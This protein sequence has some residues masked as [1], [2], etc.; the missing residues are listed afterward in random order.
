VDILLLRQ[1]RIAESDE[2][3]LIG[4]ALRVPE[5]DIL[6]KS[7]IDRAFEWLTARGLALAPTDGDEGAEPVLKVF[8]TPD[9]EMNVDVRDDPTVDA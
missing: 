6:S 1:N 8:L 7:A 2:P 9:D 5:A 4:I 3:Q